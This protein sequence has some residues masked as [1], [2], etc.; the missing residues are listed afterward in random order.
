MTMF[1][2]SQF[3][4][5]YSLRNVYILLEST[6]YVQKYTHKRLFGDFWLASL[7]CSC[8]YTYLNDSDELSLYIQ[9]QTMKWG[10]YWTM[11][12]R[13]FKKKKK[14]RATD[15]RYI[16]VSRPSMH[17]RVA[18]TK[19]KCVFSSTLKSP[20]SYCMCCFLLLRMKFRGLDLLIVYLEVGNY[21]LDLMCRKMCGKNWKSVDY[22]KIFLNRGF[23]LIVKMARKGLKFSPENCKKSL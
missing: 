13:I 19:T 16:R 1:P 8:S 7:I 23:S 14:D 21:F 15:L 18:A 10:S 2:F 11:M 5:F 6:H 9:R 22:P 3:I 20:E 17:T 12:V 4:N